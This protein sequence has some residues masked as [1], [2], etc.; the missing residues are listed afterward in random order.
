[1]KAPQVLVIIGF[2]CLLGLGGLMFAGYWWFQ[3]NKDEIMAAGEEAERAGEAFGKNS[4]GAGCVREAAANAKECGT[5]S[6]VCP[7]RGRIFLETCL[8]HAKTP[9]DFC[10]DV[11]GVDDFTGTIG[12]HEEW[13][14]EHDIFANSQ[15]C[16]AHGG[17]GAGF[18]R[19][20]RN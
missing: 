19:R 9:D 8:A 13:C 16:G 6:I 15:T 3:S 10:N 1:M 18:L 7:V 2:V 20:N 14:E 17:R 4:D 12:W 11:P 5:F